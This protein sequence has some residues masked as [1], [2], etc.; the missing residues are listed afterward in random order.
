MR[1]RMLKPA[2]GIALHLLVLAISLTSHSAMS[3]AQA[4]P[5]YDGTMVLA[6]FADPGAL[7]PALTTSV[8]THIVT[9]PMFNGLVAHDFAFN[10]VPDLA[11]RWSLS[12]DG[13]MYTFELARHALWHDGRPV[14]AA[15][16][17]FTFAE[18]LLK[19]HGRTRT[20]L[21]Q[22]LEAV[23]ARDAHTVAFRFKEPYAPFLALV[24]VVNAPIL[25]RHVYAEG[26]LTKHPANSGPVGSGPF[27]FKE[28]VRGD[29]I[30]LVRNDK[31][32]KAGKPYLDR[33]VIRIMP[34][35]AAAT[36]AFEKG[37]V[38][39]FLF[40]PPHELG[41][42]RQLSSVTVTTRGREGVCWHCDPHPEPAATDP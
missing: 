26:E 22:N 11:E 42:L 37:E 17:Q 38:D 5:L 31:Y 39:Y 20:A 32:F 29:H 21:G 4:R 1:Q 19:Y 33:I 12:D 24:D 9:G 10:P 34:D 35:A 40:P 15:D 14:S 13:R 41:R 6:T 27:K 3:W 16:V 18:V 23:E 28:W 25:P 7:N 8:P 36:I 2:Y 30:T